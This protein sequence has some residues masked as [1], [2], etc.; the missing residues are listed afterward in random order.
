[1]VDAVKIKRLIFC[2]NLATCILCQNN[3]CSE[4]I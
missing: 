1:M 3:L 2:R 4:D